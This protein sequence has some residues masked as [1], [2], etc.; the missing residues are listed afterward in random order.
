MFSFKN[1]LGPHSFSQRPRH[2]L[3]TDGEKNLKFFDFFLKHINKVN[4]KKKSTKP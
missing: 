3:G 4:L 1:A 2:D